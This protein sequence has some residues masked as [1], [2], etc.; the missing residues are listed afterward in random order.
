MQI[1]IYFDDVHPEAGGVSTYTAELL[2]VF[3]EMAAASEHSYIILCPPIVVHATRLKVGALKPNITVVTVPPPSWLARLLRR[4]KYFSPLFRM[5]WRGPGAI[6]RVARRH[7]VHLLWFAGGG[8][9]ECPDMPYVA[10][11]WDLQHRY[12]PFFPEVSAAGIWDVRE[13]FFSYFLRRAAYCVTGTETGKREIQY[14]YQLAEPRVQVLPLPTPTF[15]LDAAPSTIDV[16]THFGIDKKYIFYPAQFWPHKNHVN[17]ILALK[18]LKEQRGLEILL[19]LC[20]SDKGN[21]SF[22]KRFVEQQ[23]MADQVRFLGFVSEEELVA[24]YRQAVALTFVTYFGPDNIPPLEAFALGC[25]VIASAVEGAQEQYG[26]A[27]VPVDPSNPEAIG[28]AIWSLHSDEKLR[29]RLIEAGFERA[30]RWTWADYLKG[31][32]K[33]FD[34]FSAVRRNWL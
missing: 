18:W 32:F 33:L 10:T 19:V 11:L 13:Q 14:L 17:L 9:C 28:Q 21:L 7:N 5:V 4:L 25:P 22:I 30:K 23:G 6:E 16:R 29:E 15:A 26:D 34:E 27:V 12:Q 24:L 20:G 2:G 8:I 3:S 1:G 31:M